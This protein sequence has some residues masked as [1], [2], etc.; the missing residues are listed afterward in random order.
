MKTD[1]NRIILQ[2]EGMTCTNCAAG[3]KKHL[4]SK[5]IQIYNRRYVICL[6]F[7][8]FYFFVNGQWSVLP[9]PT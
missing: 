2:V 9:P 7:Q 3:I 4:E 8:S 1:K 6:C 5:G